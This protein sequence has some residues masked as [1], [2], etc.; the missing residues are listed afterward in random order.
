MEKIIITGLCNI[1]RWSQI[2]LFSLLSVLASLT[3]HILYFLFPTV[4]KEDSETTR[5]FIF[6]VHG[7]VNCLLIF[8]FFNC[9]LASRPPFNHHH[10]HHPPSAKPPVHYPNPTMVLRYF[11]ANLKRRYKQH[12]LLSL[13]RWPLQFYPRQLTQ[14]H[15]Y[16]IYKPPKLGPKQSN[17]S[18]HQRKSLL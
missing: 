12:S 15:P 8:I 18:S 9:T 2:N 17:E 11:L 4:R 13:G 7:R 6:F 3:L 5:F 10:H 1:Q 16:Q 14:T